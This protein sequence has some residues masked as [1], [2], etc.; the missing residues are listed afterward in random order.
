MAE[1]RN[2]VCLI[3]MSVKQFIKEGKM[4]VIFMFVHVVT[5]NK[6]KQKQISS[7]VNLFYELT[8]MHFVM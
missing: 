2:I 5:Q 3:L 8:G 6:T 7:I 4:I 1:I